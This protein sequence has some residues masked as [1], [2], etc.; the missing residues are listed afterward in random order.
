[1]KQETAVKLIEDNLT[2]IYGY[3]YGKLYDKSKAEDLS[4][5]IIV[6]VLS[7]V[8]S[9]KDD[10]SFW[11]FVWRIAENTFRKF[12]RKQE[13]ISKAMSLD[14]DNHAEMLDF[15]V[16]FEKIEQDEQIYRLRRELSL[17]S[18]LHRNICI[19]Y[20]VHNKSCSSIAK[21]FS[22]SVEMVKQH[23]F[24]ARKILKEGMKMERKLGE[25]SYNPGT[26]RLDFWGDRN[27][28]NS[29]CD[30]KLPG[31]ILLAA[32][33]RPS[34][35]EDLS[36]ELG[37]AMPYLE[38]EIEILTAAGLLKENGKKVETD[39][40]IITD[41]YEKKFVEATKGVYPQIGEK[42]YNSIVNM[43]PKI[44][45]LQFVGNDYDDNRLLWCIMSIVLFRGY[46]IASY[47]APAGEPHKLALGCNGWVFGYDNNY[48]NIH[49][50]GV[51]L[52]NCISTDGSWFAAVNYRVAE[53]ASHLSHSCFREMTD[54]MISAIENGK[55][56]CNNSRLTSLIENK[57]II[58]D[59]GNLSANFPV[60]SESVYN[61][62][63]KIVNDDAE[64]VADC[65]I[66]ISN[67][68]E[69]LLSTTVPKALK[70]EC[71]DIAK[72]HHGMDVAA[73]IIESLVDSNKLIVP[74]EK[75]PLGVFGV[76]K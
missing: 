8:K 24:K 68:A 67:K 23:L 69:A 6:E 47:K 65:M 11:G 60:F 44:R 55:A 51:T 28:Y 2:A 35:P 16:S 40:V 19:A 74:A 32:Y 50:L 14:T 43:L 7:S 38:E 54:A 20:Y 37:V 61:E 3:A 30:K 49:Y 63:L 26:L 25:K 36:V 29:I 76:K 18:K 71:A 21:E 48:E 12:I 46:E 4:S 13:L 9:L 33:N 53:Q 39:I 64:S 17:L 27:L 10:N 22:I 75:I 66:D 70:G 15:S 45:D 72:I 52:K 41:E 31:A 59:N 34:A 62:L 56:D 57:F 5:E 73:F 42:L 58:S 1:M